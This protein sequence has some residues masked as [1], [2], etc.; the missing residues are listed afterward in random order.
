MLAIF[1]F[2]V[3]NGKIKGGVE[4]AIYMVL[5]MALFYVTAYRI[6]PAIFKRHS[7]AWWRLL[8]YP[9]LTI[10][11]IALLLT[12]V[13]VLLGGLRIYRGG[14]ITVLRVLVSNFWSV[15]LPFVPSLVTGLLFYGIRWGAVQFIA[16]RRVQGFSDSLSRSLA[17]SR[18]S[19]LFMRVL[20]HLLLNLIPILRRIVVVNYERFSEA[21][22]EASEL[23]KSFARLPPGKRIPAWEEL[24]Q[25]NRLVSL[26]E[27]ATG[28]KIHIRWEL[29]ERLSELTVFPMTIFIPVENALK[30]AITDQHSTPIVVRIK[31]SDDK[32]IVE[33]E[34]TI[35]PRMVGKGNGLGMGL[36]S[37]SEQL[38][39]LTDADFLLRTWEEDGRFR[40]TIRFPKSQF[41]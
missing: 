7:D 18:Q 36:K 26:K 30:Y 12:A 19:E 22:D 20:P 38:K 5:H 15:A 29:D 21:L 35:N 2:D 10:V 23:L 6:A 16:A 27:M 24:R 1:F 34:N 8:L 13:S 9:A 11:A 33:T 25:T 14:E 31:Q 17:S 39:L 41:I 40:V 37:L 3:A 28:H 4:F 32:V